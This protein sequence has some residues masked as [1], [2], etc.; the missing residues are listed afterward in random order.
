MGGSDSRG[1]L[2]RAITS[3]LVSYNPVWSLNGEIAY[4]HEDGNSIGASAIGGNGTNQRLLLSGG[5]IPA[6]CGGDGSF[7]ISTTRNGRSTITKVGPTGLAQVLIESDT[8]S[9][10]CTPDGKWVVYA[11][12]DLLDISISGAYRLKVEL[13]A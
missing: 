2:P 12:G 3:G 6:P 8:D 1:T 4:V 7:V 5:N 13:H 11:A 10:V 9:P